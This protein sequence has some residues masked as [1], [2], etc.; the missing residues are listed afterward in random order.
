MNIFKLLAAAGVIAFCVSFFSVHA[1]DNPAQ[2][3]A[4]AMLNQMNQMPAPEPPAP[5]PAP[6]MSATPAAPVEPVTMVPPAAAAVAPAAPTNLN[7]E[8][9]PETRAIL[10]KKMKTQSP[11]QPMAAPGIAAA[12]PGPVPIVAPPL[13]ISAT[14]EQRL[15]ALL[16]L[17]KADQITP[18]EYQKRRAAI[19]AEP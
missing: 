6:A 10:M 19:L 4:R 17:Y 7:V 3:A 14:K 9:K 8:A 16:E 15:Q 2:A 12:V 18:E 1:Q 13:P 11:Q 5:P